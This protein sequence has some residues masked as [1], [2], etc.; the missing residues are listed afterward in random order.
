[1]P[2]AVRLLVDEPI[3]STWAIVFESNE[4][5]KIPAEQSYMRACELRHRWN[6]EDVGRKLDVTIVVMVRT[7]ANL[8][9]IDRTVEI[10]GDSG[11]SLKA[12]GLQIEELRYGIL[13]DRNLSAGIDH[14]PMGNRLPGST[15]LRQ[16]LD[17][18]GVWRKK[19]FYQRPLFDE[20]AP[21]DLPVMNDVRHE[22]GSPPLH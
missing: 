17:V 19:H 16:Q 7:D 4:L 2:D 11:D 13:D 20:L 18:G 22:S 12:D 10:P 8:E 9:P 3:G 15:F 5:Q 1:V 6:R 14:H 21:R